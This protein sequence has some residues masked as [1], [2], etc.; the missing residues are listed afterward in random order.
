M[1]HHVIAEI[2]LHG[3]FLRRSGTFYQREGQFIFPEQMAVVI[4][5]VQIETS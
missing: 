2:G 1:L 3:C 4:H 5:E